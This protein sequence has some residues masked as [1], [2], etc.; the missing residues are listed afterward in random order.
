[1]FPTAHL[2]HGTIIPRR[3]ALRLVDEAMLHVIE[4]FWRTVSTASEFG[5]DFTVLVSLMK[6]SGVA[7]M[8]IG[9]ARRPGASIDL[10][11]TPGIPRLVRAPQRASSAPLRHSSRVIPGSALGGVRQTGRWTSGCVD[12][13]HAALES[14]WLID[15]EWS[16]VRSVYLNITGSPELEVLDVSN[17]A[18]VIEASIHPDGDLIYNMTLDPELDAA[19]VTVMAF[20]LVAK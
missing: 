4:T 20:G 14:P 12:A 7:S 16:Q 2:C 19:N 9:Q 3:S 17:A 11:L 5:F 15:L 8:G 1:V 6:E 13:A 10:P 18:E